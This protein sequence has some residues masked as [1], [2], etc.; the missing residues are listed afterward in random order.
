MRL[1]ILEEDRLVGDWAAKYVVKRINEFKPNQDKYFVLGLPTGTIFKFLLILTLKIN[2]NFALDCSIFGIF[3]QFL[4]YKMTYLVTLF[5]RKLQVFKNSPKLT[6]F[7]IFN[8]LLTTQN[9]VFA[10]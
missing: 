3:H 5:D 2:Q 9:V 8:E 4:S 6:I 1:I 10:F 7:G